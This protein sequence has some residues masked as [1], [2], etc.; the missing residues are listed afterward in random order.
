MGRVMSRTVLD[1]V[2]R[3]SYVLGDEIFTRKEDIRIRCRN[4]MSSIKDGQLVNPADKAFLVSLFRF[5]GAWKSKSSDG[6][7]GITATTTA[8]Y[9]A[10]CFVI[11][12][13]DGKEFCVSY[14]HAIKSI[15]SGSSTKLKSQRIAHFKEAARMA[16]RNQIDQFRNSILSDHKELYCPI[17]GDSLWDV[18]IN[19]DHEP[20]LTFNQLLFDFCKEKHIDPDKVRLDHAGGVRTIL[21]DYVYYEWVDYH[22]Q[23][24]KLRLVSQSGNLKIP[25]VV[26]PWDT[27]SSID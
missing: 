13:K 23:H 27:L 19:V 17:T 22:K 4:I 6:I 18:Q 3:M 16:I 21:D 15:P 20:P 1:D 8:I 5:H 10:R 26:V 24:S 7:S 2:S 9:G 11:L 14:R 12:R 25:Y